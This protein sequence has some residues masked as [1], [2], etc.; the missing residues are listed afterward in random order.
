MELEEQSYTPGSESVFISFKSVYENIP[1]LSEEKRKEIKEFFDFQKNP[2]VTDVNDLSEDRIKFNPVI[3]LNCV[4]ENIETIYS[5]IL[6]ILP[7][8]IKLSLLIEDKNAPYA[9]LTWISYD[10]RYYKFEIY[11]SDNKNI[12]SSKVISSVFGAWKKIFKQEQLDTINSKRRKKQETNTD[13]RLS[14][15]WSTMHGKIGN[16]W[17]LLDSIIPKTIRQLSS[18]KAVTSQQVFI[19]DNFGSMTALE[20]ENVLLLEQKNAYNKQKPKISKGR[21]Q[22]SKKF[23]DSSVCLQQSLG[24]ILISRKYTFCFDDYSNNAFFFQDFDQEEKEKDQKTEIS[25]EISI[26]QEPIIFD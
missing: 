19:S 2:C 16:G 4:L 25:K 1:K 11:D 12:G 23:K 10:L 13:D 18:L 15:G 20:N 26:K 22:R 5:R 17:Y 3:R 14:R 9:E 24:E 8:K 21:K 6:P 7:M